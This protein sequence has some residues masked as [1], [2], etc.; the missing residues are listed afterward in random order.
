VPKAGRARLQDSRGGSQR[1]VAFVGI[2]HATP[3]AL[4]TYLRSSGASPYQLLASNA[5]PRDGL[6]LTLI[7]A[8]CDRFTGRF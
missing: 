8:G 4:L 2:S 7:L 5:A 6:S 3:V 1:E